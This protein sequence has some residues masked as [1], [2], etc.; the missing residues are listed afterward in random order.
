VLPVAAALLP[1]TTLSLADQ[2]LQYGIWVY[3]MVFLVI[4]IASTIA[5]GPIPDNTFLILTGA[6]AMDNQLPLGWLFVAAFAGG[7]AGYE[8]NYWSGRLFGLAIC[9]GICPGVLHDRNMMKA[10]EL[11]DR[12]G[13]V[14][15]ILSRFMPVLNL[16][17]FIAGVNGM[18]YRRYLGFNL[19]SSAV[20]C[21]SLLLAGY[22]VGSIPVVSEY[23]DY[24]ADFFFIVLAAAIVIAVALFVRDY[25]RQN[26]NYLK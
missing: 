10:N 16:P 26:R 22:F 25:M 2:L 7:F 8:I 20:W 23:L 11:M 14:S 9:R 3:L 6:V 21:G 12:Y 18:A 13:A 17:S 5:G 19:I 1:L 15:L 24:V 4:T